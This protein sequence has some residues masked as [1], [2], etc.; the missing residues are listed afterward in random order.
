MRIIFH[1]AKIKMLNACG[2]TPPVYL[3]RF[4]FLML[5]ENSYKILIFKIL[6]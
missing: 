4:D 5:K 2:Q 6:H 1:P 3:H